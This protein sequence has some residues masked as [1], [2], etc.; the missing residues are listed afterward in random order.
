MDKLTAAL[1]MS[2]VIALHQQR[3]RIEIDCFY[4][5]LQFIAPAVTDSAV[6]QAG[7]PAAA[8][9]REQAAPG[10]Q[11]VLDSYQAEPALRLSDALVQLKTRLAGGSWAGEDAVFT[12][13]PLEAA[14][15]D[16]AISAAVQAVAIKPP[17]LNSGS[18]PG[19]VATT[20]KACAHGWTSSC[21]A[22]NWP[23]RCCAKS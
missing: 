15:L 1:R 14:G 3:K 19:D 20:E 12:A 17:P 2:K 9:T 18:N 22:R 7:V 5:A 23:P 16:A 6:G 13:A 4:A 10:G 8:L 11:L 21:W